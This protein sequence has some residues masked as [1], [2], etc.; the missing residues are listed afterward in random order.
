MGPRLRMESMFLTL[1]EFS[2]CFSKTSRNPGSMPLSN[3]PVPVSCFSIPSC[4]NTSMG[5]IGVGEVVMIELEG[6]IVRVVSL[7]GSSI[8]GFWNLLRFSLPCFLWLWWVWQ[9][10]LHS[11]LQYT[12]LVAVRWGWVDDKT[13]FRFHDWQAVAWWW[14]HFASS[15]HLKHSLK[16]YRF[17]LAG[18]AYFKPMGHGFS[19]NFSYMTI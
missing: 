15:A 6:I 13:T 4:Q 2:G 5:S 16:S 14:S 3:T 18:K 1:S 12:T 10:K 17:G 8:R 19:S 9:Y 11:T 7:G